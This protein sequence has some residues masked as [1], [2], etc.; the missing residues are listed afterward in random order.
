MQKLKSVCAESLLRIIPQTEGYCLK[1]I[2]LLISVVLAQGRLFD[3]SPTMRIQHYSIL[4]LPSS[5]NPILDMLECL[6]FFSLPVAAL[7]KGPTILSLC[8]RANAS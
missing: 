7:M 2:C 5:M 8:A 6:A 4:F 1:Q 3:L